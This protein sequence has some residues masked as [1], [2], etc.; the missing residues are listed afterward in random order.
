MG[1][2]AD[3]YQE[4]DRPCGY[5]FTVT[6]SPL[7]RA[8]VPGHVVPTITELNEALML[9]TAGNDTTANA[10]IFG[11]H[12]I[13][14]NPAVQERLKAENPSHVFLTR[15]KLLPMENSETCYTPVSR[16]RDNDPSMTFWYQVYTYIHH[17]GSGLLDLAVNG[18]N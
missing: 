8:T 2:T 14:R 13:C 15:S 6:E 10:M 7:D 4:P 11:I 9:L 16:A 1:L 3:H 5:T 18:G 12:Y 17:F